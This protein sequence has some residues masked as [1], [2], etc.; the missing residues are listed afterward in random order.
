MYPI[1]GEHSVAVSKKKSSS[2]RSVVE[3]EV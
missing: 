3:A 1:I 2:F